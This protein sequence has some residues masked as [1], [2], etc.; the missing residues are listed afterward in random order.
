MGS[1]SPPRKAGCFWC[2]P[3]KDSSKKKSKEN[4]GV[5]NVVGWDK[6][7]ELLSDL[8][9]F[10][11]KKQQKMLKKAMKEEQK[12]SRE[13]EKILEWAKQT[14]ARMN[15]LDIEDELSDH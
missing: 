5:G 13:A 8:G 2:S 1:P 12:I 15:V 6:S 14:S 10:S 7:D 9:S 3:K 11:S 4:W